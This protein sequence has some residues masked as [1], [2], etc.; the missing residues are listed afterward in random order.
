[1]SKVYV[2]LEVASVNE[3]RPQVLG[4]TTNKKVAESWHFHSNSLIHYWKEVELDD[5]ELLD[6]I[7]RSTT[8][9]S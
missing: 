3:D 6:R 4:V 7:S 9:D 1:M 5:P 8:D 2:L